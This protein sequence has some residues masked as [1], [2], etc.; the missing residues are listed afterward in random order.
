MPTVAFERTFSCAP[1]QLWPYLEEPQKIVQWMKGV[2]EDRPTSP[3]PT[4]VGSTFLMR[5]REGRKVNDYQG[6]VT[7]F[8]KPK[9]MAIVMWGGCLP[10]G[11]EIA[12]SPARLA[13]TV[14]TSLRYMAS[15]SALA[16][17]SKA[18]VG[19]VGEILVTYDA[20]DTWERA[21]L[22]VTPNST[23]YWQAH[24]PDLPGVA[25]ASSVFGQIYVTEDHAQSWRKLDREFG[26]I[27]ALSLTPA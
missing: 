7:A 13:G 3:G 21:E 11:T 22:P 15:G 23:M 24:H 5:I 2:V 4:R 20:G 18:V 26:E 16:P 9:H 8:D 19:D 14:R 12:G 25:L 1:G 27:R 17:S 10:Q 6:R